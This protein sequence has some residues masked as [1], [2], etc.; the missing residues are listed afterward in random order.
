MKRFL[1]IF[2]FL[3]LLSGNSL[4]GQNIKQAYEAL[5]I[6][7]YYKARTIFERQQFKFPVESY[8]GLSLIHSKNNNPFYNID[9]AFSFY[10]L[11]K[12]SWDSVQK[13]PKQQKHNLNYVDKQKISVL[14]EQIDSI[15][16]HDILINP[17]I[18]S[19]EYYLNEYRESRYYPLAMKLRD[20]M[21]FEKALE[22]NDIESLQEFME[23]Y[24]NANQIEQAQAL[25]DKH[26]FLKYAKM[27]SLLYYDTFL[28]KYPSN[29]YYRQVLDSV[30]ILSTKNKSIEEFDLFLKKYPDNPNAGVAWEQLYQRSTCSLEKKSFEIFIQK[31]P[32][33]PMLQKAQY[34]AMMA[35]IKFYPIRETTSNGG[36]LWGFADN[37]GIQRI[38]PAY[39]WV[40]DFS[41]GLAEI[42]LN[43][44]SG[45]IKK[46]G[47][48]MFIPVFEE[49]TSWKHGRCIVK[50]SGKWGIIDK[51]GNYLIDATYDGIELIA[52]SIYCVKSGDKKAMMNFDLKTITTFD[53]DDIHIF[54]GDLAIFTKNSKY[55]FID[56]YGK[57]R[58]AAKYDY[59]E[60]FIHNRAI[61]KYGDYFGLINQNDSII[62]PFELTGI[63][64]FSEDYVFSI[65]DK[66]VGYYDLSGILVIPFEYEYYPE[67]KLYGNFMEGKAVV[68]KKGKFGV[69]D[70]NGKIV[71]P[72]K[73][74]SLTSFRDGIAT[75]KTTNWGFINSANQMIVPFVYNAV[76]SFSEGYAR[77]KKE[78]LWAYIDKEGILKTDFIFESAGDFK[79]NL[80]I[81][82]VNGY[83][84][85][86]N[87]EFKYLLTA[88]FDDIE[89]VDNDI[90][91]ISVKN[92]IAYWSK[93]RN[94]LLWSE[95]GFLLNFM[96]K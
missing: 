39:D 14:K 93:S 74:T 86:I 41:E 6:Q 50:I 96:D 45:F 17:L 79:N 24:P 82:Q 84:A 73:Y 11:L 48:I 7:D 35:D 30:Y 56:K 5:Q 94:S 80:A 25:Y 13:N 76:A 10:K 18:T 37:T 31:Y 1:Y 47:Q 44:K 68:R 9:L 54:K 26:V 87:M 90:F 3:L 8:Y 51:L 78:T 57:V 42:G 38:K 21:A 52:D 12:A 33:S 62:I 64:D 29:P 77:V 27:N 67:L 61:V 40:E 32:Y 49:V 4:S 2:Y 58:I 92:K 43:D 72:F 23:K 95:T 63:G 59:A 71:I 89:V 81:V 70:Q 75:A 46:N 15:K 20:E 22:A 91:R 34:E 28:L 88:R 65:K 69:I 60:N 83:K 55:G 53:M 66:S 19:F 36:Y 85:L 16:Y